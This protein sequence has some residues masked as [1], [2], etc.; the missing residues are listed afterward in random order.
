[1][2]WSPFLK[3]WE[4]EYDP[5]KINYFEDF[6]RV[7]YRDRNEYGEPIGEVQDGK[8]YLRTNSPGLPTVVYNPKYTTTEDIK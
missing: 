8:N 3:E 4:P 6:N 7:D 5:K 1:M 2:T